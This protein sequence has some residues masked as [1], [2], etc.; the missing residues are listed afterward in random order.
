VTGIGFL[1][2]GD[3]VA[4]DDTGMVGIYS[5]NN[6]GEY[7]LSHDFEA[8]NKGV[9]AIVM[10]SDGILITAGAQVVNL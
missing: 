7:F 6:N 3:V 9:A 4:S 5:V 8:H 1:E 2:S 10:L